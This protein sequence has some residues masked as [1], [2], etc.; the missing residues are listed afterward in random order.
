MFKKQGFTLIEAMLV[1]ALLGVLSSIAIPS[2]NAIIAEKKLNETTGLLRN[3]VTIAK[4]NALQKR[5][6]MFF[7]AN[8]KIEKSVTDTDSK[9]TYL[10]VECEDFANDA[11][12][13]RNVVLGTVIS[14]IDADTAKYYVVPEKVFTANI[15]RTKTDASPYMFVQGNGLIV[16]NSER[17]KDKLLNISIDQSG[18]TS[19]VCFNANNQNP[20]TEKVK[21][22]C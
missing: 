10:Q 11:I 17:F 4:N 3:S 1:V 16:D 20:I 14:T 15:K 5:S 7:C 8:T 22:K 9:L 18:L 21:S 2:M 6:N 12:A 13:N 19:Y